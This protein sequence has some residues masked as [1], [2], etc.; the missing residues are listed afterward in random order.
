MSNV[1]LTSAEQVARNLLPGRQCKATDIMRMLL[2]RGLSN[3]DIDSNVTGR[4]DDM[5]GY[6]I[7]RGFV[8][9][10][11]TLE[12]RDQKK[13]HVFSTTTPLSSEDMERWMQ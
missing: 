8:N 1:I 11:P 12:V 3:N 9:E 5:D 4:W 7:M 10:F 2:Q 6:K 13:G